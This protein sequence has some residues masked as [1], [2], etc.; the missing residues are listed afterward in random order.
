MTQAIEGF[1]YEPILDRIFVCDY[2]QPDTS[3][4]GIFLGDDSE[5]FSRYRFSEWRYGE[6]L[7]IGPGM[8]DPEGVRIGMPPVSLGDPIAFS[9]RHGTRLPGDVRYEHP[10]FG[11]LLVRVL[12]SEKVAAVLKG[13]LPWWN[14]ADSQLNPDQ[15]MSG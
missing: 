11:S 15:M 3:K 4:G 5:K 13:F 6:I 2:G 7:A 8:F 10:V 1:D 9:R 14:V 12:D